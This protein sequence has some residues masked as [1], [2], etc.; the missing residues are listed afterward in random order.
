MK[1]QNLKVLDIWLRVVNCSVL[2]LFRRDKA[3]IDKNKS[4]N[5]YDNGFW[6]SPELIYFLPS[7]DFN[8][9]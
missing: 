3:S 2:L 8:A 6:L 4:E 7:R 9:L 5:L 1:E